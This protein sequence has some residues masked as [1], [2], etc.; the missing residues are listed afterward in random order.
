MGTSYG[1]V[2]ITNA[3]RDAAVYVDGYYVGTV[4]NFDGTFQRLN[5][6]PGAHHVE[7]APQ[8]AERTAVDVNIQPGQTITYRAN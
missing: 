2:R 7:I 5:L 1:G 4:D 3:P 6:E 8:G